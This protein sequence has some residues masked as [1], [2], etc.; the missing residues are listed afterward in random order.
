MSLSGRPASTGPDSLA[1]PHFKSYERWQ[2]RC[3]PPGVR[4]FLHPFCGRLDKKDGVW[5]DATRR[6]FLLW[7]IKNLKSNRLTICCTQSTERIKGVSICQHTKNQTPHA[8]QSG[9]CQ[10]SEA[11]VKSLKCVFV[12]HERYRNLCADSAFLRTI[13][14]V[15]RLRREVIFSLHSVQGSTIRSV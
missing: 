11:F 13:H 15:P 3:P 12:R 14:V 2:R 7:P 6:F 10:Q 9:V 5:R 1:P 4:S 8:S